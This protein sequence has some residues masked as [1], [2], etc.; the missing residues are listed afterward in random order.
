MLTRRAALLLLITALTLTGTAAAKN[1]AS[2]LN[3]TYR[4]SFTEKELL[5][6]GVSAQE[7]HDNYGVFTLKLRDGRYEQHLVNYVSNGCNGPYRVSGKTFT[8][9]LNV[10]GCQGFVVAKWTLAKHALQL[11]VV[12]SEYPIDRALLGTK[13]LKKIG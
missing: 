6:L 2:V 9:D 11:K 4:V 10:P 3:G 8:L 7:A 5:G 1:P 12:K 13:P